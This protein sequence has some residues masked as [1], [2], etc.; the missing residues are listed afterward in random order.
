MKKCFSRFLDIEITIIILF[1]LIFDQFSQKT[2]YKRY[3]KI[4]SFNLNI[5]FFPMKKSQ[6]YQN[7][8]KY[9]NELY[10]S[11]LAYTIYDSGQHL[12]FMT[13]CVLHALKA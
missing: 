4:L 3:I 1:N 5:L 2:F 10:P 9:S 6:K 13:K 8:L 12:R 11:P 7:K